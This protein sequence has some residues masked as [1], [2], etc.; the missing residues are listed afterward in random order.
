MLLAHIA[1]EARA[2]FIEQ[3][4]LGVVDHRA[5]EQRDAH[6]SVRHLA[7]FAVAQCFD[8]EDA[9]ASDAQRDGPRRRWLRS[10][11][12]WHSGRR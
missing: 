10:G 8:T 5:R 4:Q 3:Q 1:I 6:L 2:G 11:R 7:R 12:R 9:Q